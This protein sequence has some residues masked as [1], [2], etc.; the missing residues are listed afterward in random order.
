MVLITFFISRWE[1]KH[2]KLRE[3]TFEKIQ[4]QEEKI[5]GV[6]STIR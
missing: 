4:L 6:Y 1:S 2:E 3:I 5:E